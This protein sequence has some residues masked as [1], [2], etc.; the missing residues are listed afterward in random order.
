MKTVLI[1][2][3]NRGLG[4]EFCKQY[5]EFGW[6]VLACSRNPAQAV[7]LKELAIEFPCIKVYALDVLNRNEIDTLAADLFDISLDLLICNAGIYGDIRTAGF[8]N[9]DYAEWIL[10]LE[11]NLLGVVKV[12]EAFLQNL[13]CSQHSIIAVLSSQM[14][15]ISDNRSGGCL[16]YRSSKAALNATMKSLALDLQNEGVGVMIFHPGWVKTDMGGPNALI[17]A[18]TSVLGMIKQISN[19][20]LSQTGHFLKYDGKKIPW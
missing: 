17:N 9:L 5:A 10:S 13:K 3:A 15:S 8:G 7:K 14:G 18:E 12:A 4:L 19:F 6:E 2:G 20:K 1:T 16:L 11:T